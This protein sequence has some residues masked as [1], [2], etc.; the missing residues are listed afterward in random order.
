MGQALDEHGNVLGEAFGQTKR[1][2]FD[3]L[4]AAHTNAAE[5]RIR[6]LMAQI[7]SPDEDCDRSLAQRVE[8]LERK[9]EQLDT[10]AATLWLNYGDTPSNKA[11]FVIRKD[12][13]LRM[14]IDVLEKLTPKT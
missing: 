1:E 11:G 6:S 4:E 10:I 13:P 12:K 7:E 2:V 3:K 14:L 9:A 5:I 8:E